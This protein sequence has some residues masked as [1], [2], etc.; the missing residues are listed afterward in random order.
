MIET[1][2]TEAISAIDV[3]TKYVTQIAEETIDTAVKIQAQADHNGLMLAT[4]LLEE[5]L[6]TIQIEENTLDGDATIHLQSDIMTSSTNVYIMKNSAAGR[7]IGVLKWKRITGSASQIKTP[8]LVI[9]EDDFGDKPS[10]FMRSFKESAIEHQLF[11]NQSVD[12]L[13]GELT[14]TKLH[15]EDMRNISQEAMNKVMSGGTE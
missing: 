3:A 11:K 1:E 14:A 10:R 12:N 2:L 6:E 5:M 9:P 15:L 8:S 4:Q 13:Q 7:F